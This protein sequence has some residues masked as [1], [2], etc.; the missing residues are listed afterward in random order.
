MNNTYIEVTIGKY[1]IIPHS[2]PDGKV[3]IE[4]MRIEDYDYYGNSCGTENVIDLDELFA[5]LDKANKN[6]HSSHPGG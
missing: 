3:F 2:V 4:I 6:V 5:S 1:R